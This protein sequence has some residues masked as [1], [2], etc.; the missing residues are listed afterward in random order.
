MADVIRLKHTH[1]G[2]QI[3]TRRQYFYEGE[4]P[5]NYGVIE[6]PRSPQFAH[7]ALNAW[8][9]GFRIDPDTGRQVS[10]DELYAMLENKPRAV[11][12]EPVGETST[13]YQ[14]EEIPESEDFLSTPSAEESTESAGD[15]V[16]EGSDSGGQPAGE[17]GVREG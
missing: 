9:K 3:P 2:H 11:E 12:T 16:D 1:I 14:F 13:E 5:V 8:L 7:W 6:L 17:D 10:R 4:V 15:N